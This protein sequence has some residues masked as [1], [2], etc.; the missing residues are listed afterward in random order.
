MRKFKKISAFAVS[1]SIICGVSFGYSLPKVSA[2]T[3]NLSYDV[4][5]DGIE[6]LNDL[7]TLSLFLIGEIGTNNLSRFDVDGNYVVSQ[8]D[9]IKL[10]DYLL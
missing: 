10:R 8:M 4:N 7:T 6:D 3:S 5:D 1:L 2:T 9:V